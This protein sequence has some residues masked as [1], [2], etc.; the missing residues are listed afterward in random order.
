MRGPEERLAVMR[1]RL[2]TYVRPDAAEHNG[3]QMASRRL[4]ETLRDYDLKGERSIALAQG[5]ISCFIL[6]L[7]SL[8]RAKAGMPVV[9]SW[10]ALAL[11]LLILSSALRWMLARSKDLPERTLDVLNVIDVGIF[12]SLLWSYQYAYDHPAGGSLKAPSFVLLLVL[13]ALRALRFHPRPVLVAGLA[14]VIGW[15]LFVCSAV[16]TDG[17]SALTS[18]YRAYLT[19]FNILVG[20]E[21]E[22]IV[23]LTALVLF[24]AIATYSGRKLLGRAAHAADYSEALEAAERHLEEATQ[25]R[26]R[27]ENALLELDRHKADLLEQNRRFNAALAN[28]TQGL[29]M[30]D[31]EQRLMVCNDRYIEMYGLSK[32]LAVPGTPFRTI[33]ESRIAKG[34]YT[35]DDPQR[36]LEERLSAAREPVP[37]TK[38]QELSDGRIIAIM[39]EPMEHGG[40]VATHEDI[41]Q[42]RRIE[43]RLSHMSRH[44]SLTDLPNRALLREQI[45]ICLKRAI[46]ENSSLVTLLIDLS[47]FKEVNDTLGP[48]V[49]DALLQGVAHR[50]SRRLRGVEMIACIGGDEFVVLQVADKPASAAAAMAKKIN[51]ILGTSFDVE[52]HQIVVGACI[53]IAIGPGDGDDPDQL[54][55][56][57]DLA[58]TRAKADGPGTWRFFERAMDQ[59]MQTR[60]TLERDLRA[61]LQRGEFELYYQP[62]LNLQSD[63]ITGFE[64]LLRWNHPTRGLVSP[65]EFIP[66]AEETGLI[67]PIGEW[68]LRQACSD[69]AR[70]PRGVKVA[71]NLS[72]AQFRHGNVRQAVIS[73]LGASNLLPQGLEIEVTESVLVQDSY[74]V[75]D[76]LNLLHDIGVGIALDDFGTGYSSLSYL[77]RFHFDKIKIDQSFIQGLTSVPNTSL[78]IV[79]SIVALGTSLG[80]ATTA[81]GVETSEQFE[82][83]R[84]E[85]CTEVQGFL[86][87][88]PR[89]L[90]DVLP[91]LVR[92]KPSSAGAGSGARAG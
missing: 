27:A 88:T 60:H 50:L 37:T 62:Q 80:I 45:D 20:A 18:D 29:C 59:Q 47:R 75:V 57:A 38:I 81:E 17:L 52:D 84:A 36:Y 92:D 6:V 74:N 23:A 2:S 43:A 68:T 25:A 76:T 11:A 8:A 55:K 64:A 63:A 46:A 87:G 85:G 58:L 1:M 65:T 33:I 10:V 48:S 26:Q 42:L 44:D 14:G 4:A 70:W 79:R 40:W 90:R 89:P 49:G 91:L 73:A 15:S 16:I 34:L 69:A 83:V 72:A 22:K 82:R 67:V 51:N 5:A 41:T 77:R 78:A 24:L 13:I 9:H 32:D 7:H 12:L 30:F 61:A 19:S 86:I 21:I 66:L 35:G 54:L 3:G 31:E 39:H 28:M 56:N 53:G 71:V